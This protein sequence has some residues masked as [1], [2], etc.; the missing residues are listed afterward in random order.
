VPD[1]LAEEQFRIHSFRALTI[2]KLDLTL[3]DAADQP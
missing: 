3:L 1:L 2:A